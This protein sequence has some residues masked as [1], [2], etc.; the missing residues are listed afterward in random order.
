MPSLGPLYQIRLESGGRVAHEQ[1]WKKTGRVS[2][3]PT[4]IQERDGT[5]ARLQLRMHS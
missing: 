4:A 1:E 3:E 5:L 2:E